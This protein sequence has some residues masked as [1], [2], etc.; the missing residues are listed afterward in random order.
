MIFDVTKAKI[1][2]KPGATDLRKGASG[3]SILIEEDMK[4]KPFSGSLFL[5]C[6]KSRTLL[7]GLWWDKTGFWLC[8]KRLEK[9][10][11]PWPISIEQCQELQTEELCM[12][13]KG[14]NFW[15]AHKELFYTHVM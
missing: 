12:L 7:K 5:F 9:D 15:K 13:L 3:L 6:N 11:W 10:R 1:F 14:I 4:E 2:I 8:Q